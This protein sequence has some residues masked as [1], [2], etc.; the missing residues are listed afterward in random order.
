MMSTDW[1]SP[2]LHPSF[3]D[4]YFKLAKWNSE[5]IDKA[6]R[7]TREMWEAH[8]KPPL[9]ANNSQPIVAW[10][11]VCSFFNLFLCNNKN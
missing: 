3:K 11:K 10:P 7:L 8:Y 2:V 5:W 1:K 9:Q 4:E 6:I